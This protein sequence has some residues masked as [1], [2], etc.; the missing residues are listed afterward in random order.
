M[1]RGIKIFQAVDR[2]SLPIAGVDVDIQDGDICLVQSDLNN[3]LRT[4]SNSTIEDVNDSDKYQ[5]KYYLYKDNNWTKVEDISFT[6]NTIVSNVTPIRQAH[7]YDLR[8]YIK[9]FKNIKANRLGDKYYNTHDYTNALMQWKNQE[10]LYRL[11]LDNTATDKQFLTFEFGTT[12]GSKETADRVRFAFRNGA[13]FQPVL[14]IVKDSVYIYK[15]LSVDGD[16]N[17]GGNLDVAGNITA[18]GQLIS[19]IAN[20]TAPIVVNSTTLVK[21]L[22]AEFLNGKSLDDII[23]SSSIPVGSILPYAGPVHTIP[24]GFFP[25]FGGSVLRSSYP[26]LSNVLGNIY[27]PNNEVH[28]SLV[29]LPDCRGVDMRGVDNGRG[30]DP[31]RT[32]GSYQGDQIIRMWGRHTASSDNKVLDD[33]NATGVFSGLVS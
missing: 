18:G 13:L 7:I 2:D 25:C 31:G 14:D 22:N 12:S 28:P 30:L 1:A 11:Y 19:K 17:I 16:T 21:N 8:C 29:R 15:K 9:L 23:K 33:Y 10:H 27:D 5:I 4:L 24:A 32:L 6:D 20:G 3:A 26:D